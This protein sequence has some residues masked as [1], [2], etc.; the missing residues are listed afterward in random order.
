ML[1]D[2]IT[3]GKFSMKPQK[4]WKWFHMK[5]IILEHFYIKQLL[6]CKMEMH[7]LTCI[8]RIHLWIKPLYNIWLWY[9]TMIQYDD[10]QVGTL[11]GSSVGPA[12]GLLPNGHQFESPQ[13]HWRF[14][15]SLTSG[16]RGISRGA[17]KLARTSTVIK[18]KNMMI[19][20]WGNL[21]STQFHYTNSR[22]FYH[23]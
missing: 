6:Y 21:H 9:G 7:L 18:K 19:I 10:N 23:Y 2:Y 4:C 8:L 13:G 14:T 22:V 17:R 15:Q 5:L 3:L 11:R 12:L 1:E 20:K 16:P